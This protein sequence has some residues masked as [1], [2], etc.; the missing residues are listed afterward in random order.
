LLVISKGSLVG[1]ESK[2]S[3]KDDKGAI[4]KYSELSE[5][6]LGEFLKELFFSTKKFTTFFGM[7]ITFSYSSNS[8]WRD[9]SEYRIINS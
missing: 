9:S 6:M 3:Q 5:R 2:S 4:W 7:S 1:R 8:F